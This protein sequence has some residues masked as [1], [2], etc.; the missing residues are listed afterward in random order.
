MVLIICVISDIKHQKTP[1]V[2][3][4]GS[5]Y[6]YHFIIKELAELFKGQFECLVE[7]TEQYMTLS[8]TTQKQSILHSNNMQNKIYG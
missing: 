1:V 4:N 6:D 7:N 2:F 3:N 5:N 8:G